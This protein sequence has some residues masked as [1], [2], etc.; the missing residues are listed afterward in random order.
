[1]AAENTIHGIQYLRRSFLCRVALAFNSLSFP[2][3]SGE[4]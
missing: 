3:S 2:S 1:M 4:A